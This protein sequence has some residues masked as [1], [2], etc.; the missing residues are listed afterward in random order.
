MRLRS[1]AK[2]A[3]D[4]INCK[5]VELVPARGRRWI[6]LLRWTGWVTLGRALAS[7]LARRG[8]RCGLRLKIFVFVGCCHLGC[9]LVP[10]FPSIA[11]CQA[12]CRIDAKGEATV[13]PHYRAV[14]PSPARGRHVGI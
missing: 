4:A 12:V 9:V 5:S 13:E 3:L 7:A 11:G 6:A 8:S 10:I 2:P 1:I 14:A